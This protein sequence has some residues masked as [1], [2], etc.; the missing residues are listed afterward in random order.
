MLILAVGLNHA[1][2]PLELRERLAYTSES[3]AA[4]LNRLKSICAE[5]VILDTCNRSEVYALFANDGESEELT[6]RLIDFLC[7]FHQL[8][9]QLLQAH[10]YSLVNQTAISHLFSVASGID[11]LVVGETQ[12]LA[13]VRAAAEFAVNH[14]TSGPILSALFR[15]ALRAGKRARTE[16]LI[17]HGSV[18][19]SSVAIERAQQVMGSLTGCSALLIGTGKMSVLAALNLQSMGVQR[20]WITNRTSAHAEDL[21]REVNGTAIAF[22]Q[23]GD[24]LKTC[25]LVF[26]STAAPHVIL[27]YAMI[28]EAVATR[29]RPLCIVDLALPRDVDPKVAD[30]PGVRLIDLDDLH[31][32]AENNL[33]QRRAEVCKVQQIVSAEVDNFWRWLQS[34]SVTPT[35]TALRQHAEQIRQSELADHLARLEKLSPHEKRVIESM[36]ASIVGRLLH[37]PTMRLKARAG[38]GDGVQYAAALRELFALDEDNAT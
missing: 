26:S 31:A 38:E 22:E 15:H 33:A 3:R 35:I 2:A 25:D 16:T 28:E 29:T 20:L 7:T 1:S 23:L 18:S 19:L 32:V 6:P 17:S 9:P 8:S 5:A 34:L 11:S 27:S 24:A 36:T 14:N 12:V 4:A 37:E 13:Q 10:L 30:L 21:A